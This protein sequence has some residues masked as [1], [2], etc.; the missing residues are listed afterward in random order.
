[1]NDL[2]TSPARPL[3]ASAIV[4]A[5]FLFLT[6]IFWFS[7]TD[8]GAAKRDF[9]GYWAAGR[10]M[11]HGAD[12]FDAGS[13]LA[14]EK[15][16]GLGDLQI[17][18]T[19]SPPPGLVLV[20]PLGFMS[21]KGGLVFWTMLQ[22]ACLAASIGIVWILLGRPASRLH[23]FGFLFAP[24]V[25]CIMAGQVGVLCLLGVALFL[26][27]YES[28]P[29]F[30][31]VALLPCSLKPHLFLPMVLVLLLWII[32]RK[33]F[34][35]VAGFLVALAAGDALVT[36]C[37]RPIWSQYFAMLHA[38]GLHGRFSPTLSAYLRW[39]IAAQA[40]WL[41]YLL[42]AVA[43]IWAF[44]FFFRRRAQWDWAQEGMLVLLVSVV[45]APYAWITDESM[46][47]PAVLF[48]VFRA[49]DT[50][51][52]LIPIALFAV[53]A[54]IELFAN[55]RITSWYYTWT[56][57]AWLAWFLYATRSASAKPVAESG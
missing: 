54:L 45:C 29:F 23:L 21:A 28:H 17:K 1:M 4:A 37:D 36:L 42:T 32:A 49:I 41:E 8:A 56:A 55:V 10:Q 57:P 13:V 22:I 33:A 2:N 18:L 19:P 31:G 24:A 51:R 14:L 44:W 30:A 25:A 11:V 7:L 5:G 16:V 53:I 6:L 47:L 48:A 39:D 35:I 20:L 12:P 15:S 43:C 34:A 38:G 40:G 50:R 26:Y 46:L 27:L 3:A 52:S 9:I